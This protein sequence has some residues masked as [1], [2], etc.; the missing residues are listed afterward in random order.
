MAVK[1]DSLPVGSTPERLDTTVVE[2]SDGTEVHREAV[3]ITDAETFAARVK[4][5]KQGE[6]IFD[7]YGMVI[8]GP[9][10]DYIA[11][12]TEEVLGELRAIRAHLN[13]ITDME[14]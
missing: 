10:L 12:L 6:A 7:E 13:D 11:S 1:E 4:V 14:P 5:R 8:R 3:V 2:Q 9:Q